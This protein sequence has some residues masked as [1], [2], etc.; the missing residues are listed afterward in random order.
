LKEKGG[1]GRRERGD[2]GGDDDDKTRL[3]ETKRKKPRRD[4][5]GCQ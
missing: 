2:A 3:V 5:F 4:E 1:R